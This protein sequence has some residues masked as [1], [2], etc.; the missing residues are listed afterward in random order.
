[1]SGESKAGLQA[2]RRAGPEGP[3]Y[4]RATPISKAL[5][6]IKVAGLPS[7]PASPKATADSLRKKTEQRLVACQPKLGLSVGSAFAKATADSL[8]ER[9]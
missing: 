5:E 1:M 9:S 8:R 4:T 7:R 2:R 6:R 3:A